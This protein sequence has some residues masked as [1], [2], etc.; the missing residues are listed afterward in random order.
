[1]PVPPRRFIAPLT[2]ALALVS[3]PNLAIAAVPG[4]PTRLLQPKAEAAVTGELPTERFSLTEALEAMRQGHPLLHAA[5]ANVRAA[6]A[7]TFGAGLWS[8]PVVDA[9]YGRSVINSQLDPLGTMQ[10]GY[11]QLIETANVP[12]AKQKTSAL[13]QQAVATEGELTMR[14]LTFDVESACVDLTAAASKVALFAE[15]NAD[16]DRANQVVTARVSAGAAPQYHATRIAVAVAQSRAALADAWAD[17]VQSRGEMAVAVGPLSH[18]LIGLPDLALFDVPTS[19]GLEEVLERTRLGRPDVVAAQQRAQAA[20]AQVIVARKLVLP[21]F[22]LRGG[23]YLGTAPGEIGGMVTVGV[24]LP[25]LD[26]GQGSISA[27]VARAEA[28]HAIADAAVLQAIQRVRAA[29]D[30]AMRR[31]ATLAGYMQTGV[32]NSEGMVHEAEAGYRAGKLSVLELV[33]AYVAKRDAKLRAIEL[34][35]DARQAY[36]RLQRAID[37]GASM[38]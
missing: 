16:L 31:R 18:N 9:S 6:Q 1:M 37:A 29:W 3:L 35:T 20:D 10:L 33:D 5:K 22:T 32:T 19:A 11:S 7:D 17:M 36:V 12:G 26:R 25:I 14:A 34:A 27:A 13:V 8:N 23:V 24:P 30:E 28:A 21:G 15:S 38:R 2:A 4:T